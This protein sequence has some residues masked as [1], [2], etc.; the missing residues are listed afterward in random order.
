MGL[1]FLEGGVFQGGPVF[2]RKGLDFGEGVIFS[3]WAG[4][5]RRGQILAKG[6]LFGGGLFCRDR[7]VFSHTPGIR[8]TEPTTGAMVIPV[9]TL[10]LAWMCV[11]GSCGGDVVVAEN[12]HQ[13]EGGEGS[14]E[15]RRRS[16]TST[17]EKETREVLTSRR[18][19]GPASLVAQQVGGRLTFGPCPVAATAYALMILAGIH[20]T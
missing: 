18:P 2:L 11:T 14:C 9:R 8:V 12:G 16:S 7:D 17:T 19:V 1:D 6:C 10:S 4:F 15:A 20:H 5:L 13:H 3:R